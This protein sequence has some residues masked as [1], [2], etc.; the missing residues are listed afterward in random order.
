M[1][2]PARYIVA[3]VILLFAWKGGELDIPWPPSPIKTI[4]TAKPDAALLAWADDLRPILPKMLPGDREYLAAFYDAMSFILLQDGNRTTPIVSDTEKFAVFHAGS[5]QLAIEKKNIGKYPGL[6]AAIDIVFFDAAGA[7]V[8]A[9]DADKR[10]KL[11]AACSVL[12]Y[13]FRIHGE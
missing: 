12:S 11:I 13:V 9:I 6:D 7:D 8:S 5:L 2:I 3:G 10:A 4:E 1:N